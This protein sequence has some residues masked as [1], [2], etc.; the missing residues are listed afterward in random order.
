[1]TCT[2]GLKQSL[3]Q[4]KGES[5]NYLADAHFKP[6]VLANFPKCVLHTHMYIVE[7]MFLFDFLHEIIN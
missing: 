5:P 4:V 7:G 6:C 2:I 3:I 1:M